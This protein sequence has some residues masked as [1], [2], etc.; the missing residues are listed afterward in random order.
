MKYGI[1]ETLKKAEA[2]KNT[3]KR[4]EFLQSND[5]A[6]LRQVIMM[7]YDKNLTW[8]LPEGAPPFKRSEFTDCQPNLFAQWRRMYLFF[9]GGGGDIAPM[10]R[11]TLFIQFLE[12]LDPEDADLMCAVKDKKMPYKITKPQF[13][14]AFPGIFDKINK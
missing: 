3:K 13:E 2:E 5:S 4:I 6:V 12:S 10:K 11:E 1:A 14:K 7:A 9:P 8:A